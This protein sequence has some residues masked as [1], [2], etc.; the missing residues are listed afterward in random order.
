M[1]ERFNRLQPPGPT[2]NGGPVSPEQRDWL[3]A[4]VYGWQVGWTFTAP[5]GAEC[6]IAI[7]LAPF[8]HDWV[9]RGVHHPRWRASLVWPSG[10]NKPADYCSRM[11]A[12]R[13]RTDPRRTLD[14]GPRPSTQRR[15]DWTF[16][17]AGWIPDSPRR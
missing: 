5:S 9:G 17:A 15:L 2:A 8:R 11:E 13:D 10:A 12:G 7:A 16:R 6:T 3:S 4:V 1:D 14:R